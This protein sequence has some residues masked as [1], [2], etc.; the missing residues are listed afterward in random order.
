MADNRN[1]DWT[2]ALRERLSSSELAPASD[3][4]SK[5]ENAAAGA[6]VPHR[7]LPK[8]FW[9]AAGCIAAA[10]LA[11]IMLLP[12]AGRD[13]SLQVEPSLQT[14]PSQV[15]QAA[16]S[17][18]QEP[19]VLQRTYRPSAVSPAE[20]SDGTSSPEETGASF[21]SSSD[22]Q[23]SVPVP[24]ISGSA[25]SQENDN[26][27][28]P[29]VSR[30]PVEDMLFEINPEETQKRKRRPE[31]SLFAAG[32]PGSSETASVEWIATLHSGVPLH[33]EGFTFITNGVREENI[34]A[35]IGIEPSEVDII[36]K[37][38]RHYRPVS[39]GVTL[40]YP[41]VGKWFLESGCSY[42]FLRSEYP[43]S[44][45]HSGGA[46]DQKL[47][48]LGV[49]L[50]VGYSFNTPSR[51][52]LS[53]SAGAMAEKCIYGELLGKRVNLD[54]L[55]FSAVASAAVQ[56]RMADRLSL[57]LS[58]EWSYY[59]TETELPTFRTENPSA[60]TLRLGLNLDLGQ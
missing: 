11:A 56:Y 59:F 26:R 35:I 43:M 58:P 20:S 15:A 36:W 46:D 31:V 28:A 14:A 37:N 1:T 12:D 51:F 29:S 45:G 21:E 19:S 42:S 4:W 18:V 52:S 33:L 40:S 6:S 34:L 60:V 32:F 22:S 44:F 3:I 39:L 57:F 8:P 30:R 49:P 13:V 16:D 38:T 7:V 17:H 27:P 9:W 5:V 55:Q 25:G 23:P 54:G 24:D 47:H 48:Y 2:E 10:A 50:K 53:L 41:L